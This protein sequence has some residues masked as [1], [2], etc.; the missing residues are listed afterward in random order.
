MTNSVGSDL[1]SIVQNLGISGASSPRVEDRSAFI[2]NVAS[3]R[4][5]AV[6][7]QAT[8]PQAK[9]D[10]HCTDANLQRQKRELAQ[11]FACRI[12]LNSNPDLY[13]EFASELND[14]LL[15]EQ[16]EDGTTNTT[17]DTADKGPAETP[18]SAEP[19]PVDGEEFGKQKL[20][21]GA[22]P[23][24]VQKILNQVIQQMQRTTGEEPRTITEIFNF[25]QFAL[26]VAE[27]DRDAYTAQEQRAGDRLEQL[28]GRKDP[29][30]I[31]KFHK[32]EKLLAA[33]RADK[34]NAET[35]CSQLSVAVQEMDRLD[36]S[37][38]KDGFNI[39]PKAFKVLEER[40]AEGR[41]GEISAQELSVTYCE[42]VLEFTNP[43]QFYENYAKNYSH[44]EFTHF[45]DLA[46]RLIGD[47]IG[48]GA[49]SRGNSHLVA[50]RDGLF[51][52]QI[53]HQIFDSLGQIDAKFF[54]VTRLRELEAG[55]Y[56]PKYLVISHKKDWTLELSMASGDN[57]PMPLTTVRMGPAVDHFA[58]ISEH[59]RDNGIE[60]FVLCSDQDMDRKLVR[61]F[62][63][64]L[65]M[66]Y[67]RQVF[68][69]IPN[70]QDESQ[71]LTD[72]IANPSSS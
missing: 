57:E 28:R 7:G 23:A 8:Q 35:I 72:M 10:Q 17:T 27:K 62:K 61:Q 55:T 39:I 16:G 34:K 45:I 68:D 13:L 71:E 24:G 66:R 14:T 44:I 37:R 50:I 20:N 67:G 26:T 11:T 70:L 18:E 59:F 5:S 15:R 21:I 38:I 69:A 42:S 2:P 63:N 53:S 30:G 51:Y 43:S 48:S 49:P 54:R 65:V 64:S 9:G 31:E 36:G 32:T 19:A 12:D 52:V 56:V 22:Y 41:P 3:I 46:L 29:K 47:D 33:I 4:M 58:I 40:A 6:S 60:D 1:A 25:A